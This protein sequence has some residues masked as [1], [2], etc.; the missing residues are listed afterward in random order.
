[1]VAIPAVVLYKSRTNYLQ[2]WISRQQE[3]TKIKAP[4]P[5]SDV[6]HLLV[7]RREV[8]CLDQLQIHQILHDI[9]EAKDTFKQKPMT[10]VSRMT[11]LRTQRKMKKKHK[12]NFGRYKNTV[13]VKKEAFELPDVEY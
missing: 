1:M 11:Y 4:R 13:F 12:T 6:S 9:R 5:K 8:E 10:Q 2:I 3:K 7:P